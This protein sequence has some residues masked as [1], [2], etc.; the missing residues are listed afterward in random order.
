MT[1]E[2]WGARWSELGLFGLRDGAVLT[3]DV[4]D[5]CHETRWFP[6]WRSNRGTR[7]DTV[8]DLHFGLDGVSLAP[9]RFLYVGHGAIVTLQVHGARSSGRRKFSKL[10]EKGDLLLKSRRG[11]RMR[12]MRA[13]KAT[14]R[15]EDQNATFVL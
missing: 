9:A 15:H 3:V 1:S 2:R 10:G 5:G 8:S 13:A 11:S 12:K 7:S 4:Y 14:K 6:G